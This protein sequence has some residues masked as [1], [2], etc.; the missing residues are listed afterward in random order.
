MTE[1]KVAEGIADGELI[2]LRPEHTWA[3][4]DGK[5]LSIATTERFC[6]SM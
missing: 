2:Q 5:A 3:E 1:Q 6:I 4:A